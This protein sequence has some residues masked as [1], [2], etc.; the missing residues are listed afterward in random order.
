[1][2]TR[3]KRTFKETA[4]IS[5]IKFFQKAIDRLKKK[6]KYDNFL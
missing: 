4:R 5:L 6:P 3:Q 1:M 2:T